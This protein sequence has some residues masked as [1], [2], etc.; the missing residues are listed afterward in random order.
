MKKILL[1]LLL[2]Y[3]TPLFSQEK[4]INLDWDKPKTYATSDYALTIPSFLPSE[5]FSFDGVNGINFV[6]QWKIN[7]YVN[8]NS[9][10]VTNI[11]YLPISKSELR[12]LN[13]KSIPN[14]LEFSLKNATA[15]NVN[16]AVFTL[17]P[18][19]KDG[20]AYKKISSFTIRYT[21]SAASNRVSNTQAITN[22]VLNSGSWYRFE[23]TTSGVYKLSKSFLGQM[24]IN[25]NGLDPRNIKL[26]GNGG[27]MMPFA[28]NANF[29]FDPTENA[30]KVIGEEDGVFND[31][32]Y[33]LFYAQGPSADVNTSYINTNI[34]PYTDKTVY[35]I[36]ISAG[37]GKRIQP[38]SQPTNAPTTTFNTFHDY[39]FYELDQNNIVF[40][41][42]RWFGERFGVE[43]S[44]TFDFNFPNLI[45]S[46]PIDLKVV[47][48]S[49][50]VNETVF[51]VSVNNVLDGT[52][53]I[54]GSNTSNGVY[55]TGGTYQKS[56]AVSGDNINITL[57]YDN[58]GNP[59]ASAY[60]DYISIEATRALTF[61][62]AQ[63]HFKN[64]ESTLSNGVA[65]Y[66]LT[67]ASQ[68]QE[69]WDVSNIYDVTSITNTNADATFSFNAPMGNLKTFITV[70]SQNYFEPN[71]A[72]NSIVNNQNLKGTIFLNSQGQFQDIDYLMLTTQSHLSQ[73][74]RLAQ[75]NRDRNNLNVKVV[76]LD[77]I[78]TE[79]SSGNPD[80]TGIRN[81]VKYVYDNASS[82]DNR[83]KYL[84]L[85]GDSS[86]DYKGRISNNTYNF[87]TWNAYNSFTLSNSFI[88]DDFYAY[89][90]PGE[91][92]MDIFNNANKLDIAV[93]R[94][95]ADSPL[96]AQQMVDKIEV[97]YS[98]EA[99][100][101]W[102]NNFVV[103]SDDIDEAW[104][105]TLQETT[106]EI[107]DE[108]TSFK[109]FINVTK[110]HSDSYQQE[111][112]AGGDRYPEVN[113]AISNAIERGAIMVN[114]FGHG[115]EDGL[116]FERIFQKPDAE[117]L[118]NDCKL[119][120]FVTVTC[121][122][123][124]FDNP[125]RVTAG[126][127]IYWNKNAGAIALIT[128]TR[129]IFV[130][131]GKDF[132]KILKEY[133]FSYSTNDTYSDYEY[134]TVAEALRLAKND[135][136]FSNAQKNLAFYIGDP[137][138][139]LTIP[140][141][142]IRLTKINDVPIA[143]DTD[144]LQALSYAKLAGEVTDLNGNVL[145]D[146]N[147]ILTTTIYDKEI[148]RET[149][150]NDNVSENGQLIKL[151]FSTLGAIVFRG[152]A[153]I[154][155][156]QFEFDFVVPKD[157]GIPIGTGKVSFYAT[158]NN[159]LDD[160]TGASIET[161]KIGG[162]N[163]NA[164]EDNIGPTIQL[165]M[166]DES[167]VSGGITNESPTLIAK[168][169]DDNG[170]NTAS[171][172][173]HDI[174]ALIDGDEVNPYVL[175]DYYLTE[176]D[177]YTK[178]NLS[179]PF[180]NLEPGLHTLTLKAWDVYN[181]SAIAEIQFVVFNEN[182]NLVIN[183]VL[184]YPNPFVNY[185]EFW[186]SHNSSE[187][188][189]ISVQIFTISGKLVRTLNGQTSLAGGKSVKS[190]S[191]DIVW[192]GRDDFGDKIGK[193]TYIYKLKVHSPSTNKSVEKIEK[194]VIL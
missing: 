38:F 21:M 50:A 75:I 6:E 132:N 143:Q 167:F 40:V 77:Q 67:N 111:A 160:K 188:L 162:I 187:I 3:F 154:T 99:L 177:D 169:E 130:T 97:Y 152:Q 35:Y 113:E 25:V 186:F 55:A 149:L 51:S 65:S 90:D 141:P 174:V 43:N 176:V 144:V 136:S 112:S 128:T 121:E 57:D 45:T 29:P 192:D 14:T 148:E 60:L 1:V 24:G 118:N 10:S 180:R 7:G 78:Y 123:T 140:Q 182:E 184:N 98:K 151:N 16:Y 31:T 102:R 58:Q 103:V 135:P 27:K 104:E 185:T 62:G 54:N 46:E 120:L 129:Q 59:S 49:V 9:V 139:T 66:V 114:Y 56:L 166:N 47:T 79:F 100:G 155:N 153:T 163:P 181:N 42:R 28:N 94:I 19:I 91:G 36:N 86:F 63:F 68:V 125:L 179:F 30:I 191:R 156:G 44:R 161:L 157:I 158:Q 105:A 164:A 37:L 146:Y 26:F 110:I 96:R 85:F 15:R 20:N 194:L 11:N 133:L 89:V 134:P 12:D 4:K 81:F 145:S 17:S 108:V 172:I 87:P 124:R 74:Q 32:D 84:C 173:G 80:I 190:T 138:M 70:S 76:T 142:N 23:V 159:S 117:A 170:I 92:V 93:G 107:A 150:A 33:I 83:V 48:A 101:S 106:D 126:E 69:I 72:A 131:V 109:P 34:N 39:K 165:Y 122:F 41:G 2:L 61:S 168:F 18:I 175:N 13:I 147:G 115:G 64:N 193:G 116:A 127:L 189:D 53:N 119:N 8:E 73:A 171:G 22:S 52:F 82:P 5:N 178:G 88:S 183:N 95:L 71:L 137:A